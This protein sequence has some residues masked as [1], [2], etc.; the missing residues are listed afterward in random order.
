MPSL[1]QSSGTPKIPPFDVASRDDLPTFVTFT[2]GAELLIR[3]GLVDSITP[4]GLRYMARTRPD[5]RFGDSSE[6]TPYVYAGNVR[7]METGIF[8]SMFQ[9]G[10][11]RGG[12]GRKPSEPK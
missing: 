12:R 3:L 11:R 7:T 6:Q 9:E 2:T 1:N 4:D 5:W 10:P 8:L